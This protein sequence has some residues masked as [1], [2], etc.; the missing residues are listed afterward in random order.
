MGKKAIAFLSVV[1]LLSG[2][3]INVFAADKVVNVEYVQN[4]ME[5]FIDETQLSMKVD[6]L[7]VSVRNDV[8]LNEYT[9]EE[10]CELLEKD[11][12]QMKEIMSSAYYFLTEKP[13]TRLADR[14][15]GQYTAEV[16]AGV[17]AVGWST[18]KQDFSASISSGKVQSIT[19]LGDGYMDGVSW[20]QYNHINSWYEIYSSSTKVDIY[21]KGNIN[22][23]FNLVNV[24]LTSTFLEE[25]EVS[26]NSLVRQW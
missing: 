21:I 10:I 6:E 9:E 20:G 11:L 4:E 19:F 14:G 17:P 7:S 8:D 15:N 5:R 22:Y 24:N 18:V 1:F 3:S 2:S 13:Q 25:L 12:E 26:G 23:L 16:W